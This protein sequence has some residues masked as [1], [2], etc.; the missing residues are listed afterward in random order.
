M[1]PDSSGFVYA[2]ADTAELR[3]GQTAVRWQ[4]F[5]AEQ[6]VP[7]VLE[8]DARDFLPSTVHMVALSGGAVVGAGRLLRDG[9]LSFRVGRVAVLPL[10]RGQGIGA[11]L[12]HALHD[13]A[14]RVATAALDKPS[15]GSGSTSPADATV[16]VTLDAQVR[17]VGFYEALGYA[18]TDKP[19][20]M[21]A[22]IL[23]QEMVKTSRLR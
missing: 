21:D 4:V 1:E 12:M 7:P 16:A 10:A 6:N 11:G 8:V 3:A 17:A 15:P 22:G 14:L 18:P 5:V 19:Q 9:P 23:H 13:Q 20:F 2:V